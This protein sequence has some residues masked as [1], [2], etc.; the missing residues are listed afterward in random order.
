MH[1]R[2]R[3]NS[4][5]NKIIR[6]VLI[7]VISISITVIILS[8]GTSASSLMSKSIQLAAKQEEVI[9]ESIDHSLNSLYQIGRL[10]RDNSIIY[11]DTRYRSGEIKNYLAFTNEVYKT[12]VNL[13]KVNE[14]IDY[15]AV[16]K[17][18]DKT[19]KYVGY[20]WSG[21]KSKFY[22]RLLSNYGESYQSVYD[23]MKINF[24]KNIFKKNKNTINLYF[25]IFD[26]NNL[27]EQIGLVCIGINETVFSKYFDNSFISNFFIVDKNHVIIT[28]KIQKN[29]GK[30]YDTDKKYQKEN[31]V[32]FARNKIVIYNRIQTAGWILQA[33]IPVL[34]LMKD[35][36]RLILFMILL[37][38]ILCVGAV[39]LCVKMLKHLYKPMEDLK[40]RMTAVSSGDM[41]IRMD[42]EYQEEE[43]NGMAKSFN[44]MVQNI[45]QL[46]E[47]IREEQNQMKQIELNALQSQIKP[48]F[49]YNTLECILMQALMDGNKT[50]AQLVKA[51]ASFYRLC[52]SKGQD[53]VPLK[54]EM[55]HIDS[56]LI[57]QNI[58]YSDIIKL[59]KEVPEEFLGCP[60]PKMTLQPL[61]ENCI[62]HGIKVKSGFQGTILISAEEM[63]GDMLIKISDNGVGM[64]EEQLEEI[65]RTLSVVDEKYGYGIR[66]VH[67]RIE[68]LYGTGYGL[69]YRSNEDRGV[70]VEIRL[71][72]P[73][74]D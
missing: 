64:P 2:N 29:V 23:D 71:P 1:K 63:E 31:D 35:S 6:L 9:M 52:L 18:N 68:I 20:P 69:C 66:N 12:L 59:E 74:K 72:K 17:Y 39:F 45:E 61:I 55:E 30:R 24:G 26:E 37:L 41:A 42:V 65:N 57:I 3:I 8:V 62:Y 36:V 60:I 4:F 34:N 49:L 48:H 44:L 47:R 13:K 56:Y 73:K 38:F 50:V 54:Q 7:I 19:I 51:L 10:T 67:K 58:R 40:T 53:I 46:M 27:Y 25:A 22:Y 16:L 5:K 15:I 28:D 43:F 14:Y 11:R 21:E 32:Y 33:E 70:T